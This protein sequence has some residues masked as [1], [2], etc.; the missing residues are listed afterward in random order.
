MENAGPD[1]FNF[2]EKKIE[3]K[4]WNEGSEVINTQETP[5]E[6]VTSDLKK[7]EEF[8]QKHLCL[9]IHLGVKQRD[10]KYIANK[11]IKCLDCI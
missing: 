5:P 4:N 8:A 6:K 2:P 1:N 9:P 7:S 3:E 10:A 11:F